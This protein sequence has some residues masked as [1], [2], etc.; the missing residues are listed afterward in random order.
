MAVNLLTSPG[1][2][3]AIWSILGWGLGLGFHVAETF[4]K[5]SE[6]YQEEFEKWRYKRSIKASGS[7]TPAIDIRNTEAIIES[8]VHRSLDAGHVPNK[9]AA[10]KSLRESTGLDLRDAKH[11]V[12]QYILRHPSLLD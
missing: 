3:W 2:F 6:S 11:A 4:F 9:I 1:Y 8:Y 10:I 5:N 12:D 7:A